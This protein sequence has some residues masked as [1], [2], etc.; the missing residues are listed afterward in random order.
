MR[1]QD[2]LQEM[3]RI[4]KHDTKIWLEIHTI[5][6]VFVSRLFFPFHS[7]KGHNNSS[8]GRIIRSLGQLGFARYRKPLVDFLAKE[9]A[10]GD[11]LQSCTGDYLSSLPCKYQ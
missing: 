4:I 5:I 8:I 11:E 2:N 7:L 9:I 6:I 10:E 3:K 1:K